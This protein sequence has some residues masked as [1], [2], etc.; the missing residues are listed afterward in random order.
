MACFSL[1]CHP[2]NNTAMRHFTRAVLFCLLLS[3]ACA[4][5]PEKE[6]L[7]KTEAGTVKG[8]R[9]GDVLAFT[10]IP[11]CRSERFLPPQKPDPWEGVLECT[12]IPPLGHAI[13]PRR[14]I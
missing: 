10:N 6:I 11:Y 7:V 1:T 12:T 13:P 2:K 5:D 8:Y 4:P 14:T 3:A 9:D